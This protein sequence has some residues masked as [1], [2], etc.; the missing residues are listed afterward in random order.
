MDY[1]NFFKEQLEENKSK[2][3]SNDEA[4]QFFYEKK[5][6]LLYVKK[7][8]SNYSNIYCFFKIINNRLI[9]SFLYDKFILFTKNYSFNIDDIIE[10]TVYNNEFCVLLKNKENKIKIDQNNNFE[11][12]TIYEAGFFLQKAIFDYY[13]KNN[14]ISNL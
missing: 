12:N 6:Q 4:F 2:F 14:N 8:N 3:K 5:Y 10:F 13:K 9:I 1:K 7:S 11:H